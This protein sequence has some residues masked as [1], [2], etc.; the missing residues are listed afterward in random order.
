MQANWLIA[1]SASVILALGLIHLIYTFRGTRL[2]PRDPA[3]Q[4]LMRAVS[5]RISAQT[6]MWRAWIGFNASHSMGALLFGLIYL[7]LS[8]IAP[9]L[10]FG[11]A[12]LSGLGPTFLLGWA[13]LGRHY[14]FSAPYRAVLLALALF[15]AGLGWAAITAVRT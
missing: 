6:T 15:A 10:L 4:A 9:A 8:L 14:W 7:Y 13:L 5:P 11:S 2:L 3:L 12:F 1:A